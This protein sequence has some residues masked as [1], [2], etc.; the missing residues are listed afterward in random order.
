MSA[1][2]ECLRRLAPIMGVWLLSILASATAGAQFCGG[3]N[4]TAFSATTMNVG[5]YNPFLS[6][7]PQ[8]VTVTV[9]TNTNCRLRLGFNRSTLPAEMSLTSATLEYEIE[10]TGGGTSYLSTSGTPPAGNSITWTQGAG[11]TTRTVQVRVLPDQVVA[12]GTY[13]DTAVTMRLASPFI[14]WFTIASVAVTPSATVPRVCRLDAPSPGTLSFSSG[15]IPDGT[16]NSAIIKST[17]LATACTAPTLVQL[18]GQA[19]QPTPAI[20]AA[21]GFDN[22]INY[23]AIAT[24]GA[25]TA[26]LTTST[27][28]QTV[29]SPSRNTLSGATP[30]GTVAVAVNLVAGQPIIAGNYAGVLTVIVDPAP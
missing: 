7:T 19:L 26:T 1:F 14:F 29:T 12:H 16:P 9:T 8:V 11:T 27:T 6:P 25:A 2:R 23:R 24:F 10:Q 30:S 13:T 17:T 15:E 20:A 18:T 5:T 3:G 22:F 28:W 21:A 4:I